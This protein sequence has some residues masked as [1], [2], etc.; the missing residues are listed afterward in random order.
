MTADRVDCGAMKQALAIL[1]LWSLPVAAQTVTG[2]LEGRTTDP[3]GGVV[4]G[5]EVTARN[6]ETGLTRVTKT[7]SSGYF[8]ITFLPVGAYDVTARAAGFGA[9]ARTAQVE[10]S[11][12]REVDFELKPASVDT[13]V[14]VTAE[15]PLIDT[16]RGDLKSTMDEKTIEDRPLSSRNILSL[17]EQLPGFQSTGGYTCRPAVTFPAMAPAAGRYRSRS[18]AST[19]TTLRKAP[20]AIHPIERS[21]RAPSDRRLP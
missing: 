15:S 5:A 1:V 4:T 7:N 3:S 21:A 2:T 19:M 9:V 13:A 10:L 16:S 8:Q 6:N 11:S 17:V 14:T 20:I 18:T 12:A